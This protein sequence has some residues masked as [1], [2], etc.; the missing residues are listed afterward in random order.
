VL[1][2][3]VA[4]EAVGPRTGVAA[5]LIVAAVGAV[6]WGSSARRTDG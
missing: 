6:V 1:G 5:L 2:S 3:M 4:G